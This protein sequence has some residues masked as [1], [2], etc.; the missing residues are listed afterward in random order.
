MKEFSLDS[1]YLQEEGAIVLSGVQALVRVPLDQHRADRRAGL[2]TA[3]LISG[4]RGSPLGGFDML[5]QRSRKVLSE[6]NVIFMP[7][8]NEDLGATAVFG[9]QVANL[10]PDPK[11]D[12]VL[13][14]WYGK[15]PGVD[16]T[17][18]A[19]KHANLAGVGRYGGVLA[20]AGDD[21][22]SKSS[23]I[24]S[25]SEVALYDAQMPTLYPGNVQEVIELGRYGFELSRFSGSWV[26]LKI[27]TNVADAFGTAEVYPID[28]IIRP[29]F[30]YNGK[31]WQHTQNP[32]LLPPYSLQL[33]RETH[34][35]R[36]E[37]ARFFA[38]ANGLNRITV[39][40]DHDWL[41]IAAAG[42]T[43]YDVREALY[44]LGLDDN[45]LRHYGI[46]LLKI[47]V[48]YP[49]E[50]E[51]VKAFA[52]GLEEIFVIEEKRAF[53]ELFLRDVLYNQPA[54]P[55]MVGKRDEKGNFLVRGDSELDAD[56]I[57][58][59]L[60]TRL[61]KKIPS[62][63]LEKRLEMLSNQS[64]ALRM[65]DSLSIARTPYFC[66][67]CPHNRG[68]VIPEGSI[69]A[70]GIGCHA[71]ALMMDRHTQGITHM[72]G[73]GM[74]W[75]G[76]A[77]F[78]NTSHIF[79]NI[80]D[81]T[82]FHSGSLAI[83]Q[84]VTSGANI[85]YK[86]LYNSAVGMTGGQQADGAMRVPE[87]TR[88][89]EA[90]GVRKIIVC[91]HNLDK[92]AAD[93]RWAPG[94]EVWDR[95]RLD[96]AQ[97]ILRKEKGVTV[98]IYDQPCAADLRRKRKRG[99]VEDPPMR[100]F[101]NESVCEGCGDCGVKS[102]CL[103]VLP[104]ETEFGRKTQIHQSSCNKDY[105]CLKGNCPSFVT[106]FP[107]RNGKSRKREKVQVN[108]SELPEPHRVFPKE[109]NIYMMGIGGTG[110]VTVNEILATAALIE[111]KHVRSLDQTGMSQ[112]GGPVLSHLKIFDEPK[113]VSSR[114]SFATA[115][116]YLVFD[117]LSGAKDDNLR[118]ANKEKTIAVVS[119]SQMATGTMVR[120][121]AVDFPEEDYLKQRIEANTQASRN[122]YL[123]AVMLA[124][125]LFGSHMLA[126]MIT[127]G[128]AYQAGFLPLSAQAIERAIV[129][130]DTSVE[131]NIQ[132]FQ[133]GRMVVA[134]PNWKP[135]QTVIRV[136]SQPISPKL[137]PEAQALIE[138]VGAKG[139]LRRLLEIRVPEL[140]EYQDI[141]YARQ[142]VEFVKWVK[143]KEKSL[144]DDTRLSEG[145]ARY[146]FKLMAYKDEYEV[147]RLHLRP[148]FRTALVEQFGENAQV[149]YQ[150]HPPL[151][152]ALGLK[153][154]IG[155]GK[156][157]D[158]VYRLLT[159]LKGLR[160][161]PFD[162]FGYAH[163]RKVERQLIIEYRTLIEQ[164]LS[165]LSPDTYERAVTIANLPDMVRGYEDIKLSNVA[166]F[167]ARVQKVQSQYHGKELE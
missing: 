137:T 167:R 155:F 114:V 130:N 91:T 162:I 152:R 58:E 147:A 112:K 47:G 159:K 24:A 143:E 49:M 144:T 52:L 35:G 118:H 16:R 156:W 13:G 92:Y 33:E 88:A 126:N 101:I 116:A 149:A 36:L 138:F 70:A 111:G 46:R 19:F 132:A 82:L 87:L 150:L 148:E 129:L 21:P 86:I 113:D 23:T 66:S 128:A 145:I 64:F 75:V 43:Y 65:T 15:G 84:A 90:E 12:G 1:K 134:N 30:T 37:A 34:E 158:V 164:E 59:L 42:K 18:D 17:G 96:E 95:D 153:N 98:L 50:P 106:V 2:R 80:G 41:G 102:N 85:T 10:L 165:E 161:T 93:A 76:A 8:V 55:L 78:T 89:L 133:V 9:S 146:L 83:R 72:G 103:S 160:S 71:L 7:G 54:R 79:Q 67:G 31:P 63:L 140:I 25:H 11:Y 3:T 108:E 166:E 136:G 139:E 120:S 69:A 97:R 60:V 117:I 107:E 74:Q 39:S 119:S 109:A 122:V 48:M 53:L 123:D 105:T 56:Q 81:G 104:V 77:P 14:M 6:H 125:N 20:L 110:V 40:G 38:A 61:A 157:F 141:A 121:A 142:Y 94:V 5:L 28:R 4:Y 68:T 44:L 124:E 100:I 57:V 29:E 32:A 62:A 27:V 163:V 51:I 22:I 151:L 127:V 73:E 115:D 131:A 26:G 135:F 45:R 154:K 99:Q